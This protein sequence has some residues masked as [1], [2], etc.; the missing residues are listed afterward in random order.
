MT[1][2]IDFGGDSG[3]GGG[4]IPSTGF[5]VTVWICCFE[6]PRAALKV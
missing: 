3:G 5:N 2:S 1:R 6:L 4:A